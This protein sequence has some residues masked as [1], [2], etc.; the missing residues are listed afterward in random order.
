MPK[1]LG[2]GV[3][4]GPSGSVALGAS[5]FLWFLVGVTSAGLGSLVGGGSNQLSPVCAA[6][7]PHQSTLSN[8]AKPTALRMGSA[9]ARDMP[10]ILEAIC[11]APFAPKTNLVDL[12]PI[13]RL[14][15]HL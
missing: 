5:R 6:A 10:Q 11:Y 15:A 1:K 8:P 7:D 2:S 13:D 4:S 9:S 12:T 14:P 3:A